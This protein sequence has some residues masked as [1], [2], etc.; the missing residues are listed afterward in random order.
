M[1]VED[2]LCFP[3]DPMNSGSSDVGWLVGVGDT[4]EEAIKHLKHN[5]GLLPHGVT[6]DY[7]ALADLLEEVKEA[8]EKGMEFTDQKVPEPEIVIDK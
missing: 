2:R 4:M 7:S 3:P 1:M 5:C 6:C 8:E